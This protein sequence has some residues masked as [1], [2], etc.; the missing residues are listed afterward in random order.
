MWYV[1]NDIIRETASLQ[2]SR[3]E[4]LRRSFTSAQDDEVAVQ[5]DRKQKTLFP[6]ERGGL[7]LVAQSSSGKNSL[8]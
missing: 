1:H 4:R 7:R 2:W 5:D 3:E 6:K 8:K